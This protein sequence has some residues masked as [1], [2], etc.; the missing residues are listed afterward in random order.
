MAELR[1]AKLPVRRGHGHFHD[2]PLTETHHELHPL[3]AAATASAAAAAEEQPVGQPN[4][5][6]V[7][8]R[9]S[10]HYTTKFDTAKRW[11]L[12]EDDVIVTYP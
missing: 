11:F 5:S 10:I 6:Q 1:G 4:A 2:Q 8:Q 3:H 9:S 12:F 7:F